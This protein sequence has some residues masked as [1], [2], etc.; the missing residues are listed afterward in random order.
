MR[1]YWDYERGLWLT[2]RE[3]CGLTRCVLKANVVAERLRSG[4]TIR[5]AT[6][7]PVGAVRRRGPA[8]E[9][10][11]DWIDLLA[12]MA[13]LPRSAERPNRL[14]PRLRHAGTAFVAA[15]ALELDRTRSQDP[16][17]YALLAARGLVERP[18][19]FAQCAQAQLGTK[20]NP[21]PWLSC[22]YHLAI[23]AHRN[24]VQ[25]RAHSAVCDDGAIDVRK[26][27]ATCAL[28]VAESGGQTLRQ[29]GERLGRVSES[30][31]QIQNSALRKLAA[32][33]EVRRAV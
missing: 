18:K 19:T 10:L 7:E 11:A 22:K 5:D 17:G 3:I 33:T 14:H 27:R 28:R 29:V 26:M 13:E 1:E 16:D 15:T 21:C 2:V 30:V 24:L 9:P 4:W 23:H 31:R 32:T 6:T 25:I 20:A 12:E 8:P